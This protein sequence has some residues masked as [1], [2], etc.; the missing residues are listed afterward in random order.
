MIESSKE[1][2]FLDKLTDTYVMSSTAQDRFMRELVVRTFEPF[3]NSDSIGLELGCSDG[4]MTELLSKHLKSMDVAD[5]SRKFLDMVES[6]NLPN[7][8][9]IHALFEELG[10]EKKYD[11]IFAT[12]VL[13]HLL[14]VQAVLSVVKKLLKPNGMLFIVVPNARSL[15][16]QLACQMGLLEGLKSLTPNDLNHGHKRVFDRTDLN[17]EL[18]KT[19]LQQISQGGLLLKPLADF[20]MS[21][22]MDLEILK[23]EQ[24]EGLCRLGNEYPDLC[25]ALFSVCKIK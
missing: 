18:D 25:S 24:L 11:C 8:K 14:D 21:K 22:L 13:E 6:R 9:T 10:T 20:Q 4:Y 15:S 5:G 3:I 1:K 16:R 19:G 17:R 7:V 12:Y 23:E 2:Q